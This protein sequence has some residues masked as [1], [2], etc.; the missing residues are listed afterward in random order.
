MLSAGAGTAPQGNGFSSPT[1]RVGE[2]NA[3][4]C[5]FHFPSLTRRVGQV[6]PLSPEP[7]AAAQ[8]GF[9]SSIDG[10]AAAGEGAEAGG[11]VPRI[12]QNLLAIPESRLGPEADLHGHLRSLQEVGHADSKMERCPEPLRDPVRGSDAQTPELMRLALRG[13]FC[14]TQSFGQAPATHSPNSPVS[15]FNK[16]TPTG[17]SEAFVNISAASCTIVKPTES[18]AISRIASV[19]H[20]LARPHDSASG[21]TDA[22]PQS[23]EYSRRDTTTGHA[24]P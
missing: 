20:C 3:A 5:G 9:S 12:H 13:G 16:I 24:R 10:S 7:A 14:L 22:P 2:G 17:Q 6:Y 15:D 4:K 23:C 11:G 21:D 8:A 18:A 1:R 19:A